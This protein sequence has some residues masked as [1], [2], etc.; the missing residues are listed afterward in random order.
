MAETQGDLGQQLDTLR[1]DL[2]QLRS[3][4]SEMLQLLYK[5]GKTEASELK[6]K[7][8][9][10]A[11]RQAETLRRKAFTARER[12]EDVVDRVELMIEENPVSSVLAALGIG[13]LLGVVTSHK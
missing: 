9:E 3:D 2:N 8:Q 1:A 12:G 10:E 11:S 5:T 6:D 4:M 13:F 7:V